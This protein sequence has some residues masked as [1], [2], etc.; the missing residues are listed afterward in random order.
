[1]KK[2]IY[3]IA[4]LVL[5][6]FVWSNSSFAADKIGF[7][8]MQEIMLNSNAGKKAKE[9]FEKLIAKK[10]PA[11]ASAENELKKLKDDLDKQTSMMTANARRDKEA[12]YQK[13]L[14]DYQLLV[15]DTN[16]ELQS[17]DQELAKVLIPEILKIVRT[18]G[19]REKYTLVL[20]IANTL[21]PYHE[22]ENDF[23]KKVIEEYNKIK[24]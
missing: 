17:R 9:D 8:N 15:K 6:I 7:I 19:E 3:L 12:T 2:N 13:K 21:V 20:D 16:D 22:K 4:G 10:K 1:M 24:K 18:I 11:I 23:S 14:R 5:L